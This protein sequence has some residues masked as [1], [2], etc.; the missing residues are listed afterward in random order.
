MRAVG[1]GRQVASMSAPA[2]PAELTVLVL[3]ARWICAQQTVVKVGGEWVVKTQV[4]SIIHSSI[5]PRADSTTASWL[6]CFGSGSVGSG[7][8]ARPVRGITGPCAWACVCVCVREHLSSPRFYFFAVVPACLSPSAVH[9]VRSLACLLLPSCSLCPPPRRSRTASSPRRCR[10]AWAATLN[11][12]VEA[13][14]TPSRTRRRRQ[15]QQQQQHQQLL[16]HQPQAR[17]Q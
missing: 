6:G 17:V 8:V 9:N 14:T 13:A 4:R 2:N 3:N 1:S 11:C 16:L 5:H 12:L 15:Q 10:P 7:S